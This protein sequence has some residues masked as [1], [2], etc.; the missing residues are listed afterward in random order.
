MFRINGLRHRY[1][2]ELVLELDVFD[3]DQGSRHLVLG[4]SGSGKTTL[5]HVMAGLRRPTEGNVVVAGQDLT[6]LQGHDL[7]RFRGR[8]IGIVFQRMHLFATLTVEDNLLMAPFMA[9]LPQKRDRAHEVLESLDMRHKASAYPRQLSQGQ[10][11]RV[12][13]ARAVMNHPEVLIADEP[14]ASLDDER[15]TKVLQLLI[16]QAAANNATL[17]VATHDNRIASEFESRLVL[18]AGAEVAA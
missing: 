2:S 11:Q 6:A 10:R 3:G 13:I 14:T 9:G 7:D 16:G 1:G 12:A 17:I 5:L 8:H 15:A 4:S 18:R